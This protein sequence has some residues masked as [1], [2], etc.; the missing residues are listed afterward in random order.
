[1]KLLSYYFAIQYRAK[2]CWFWT[3]D[4]TSIDDEQH[5]VEDE[6][7]RRRRQYRD[8]EYRLVKTTCEWRRVR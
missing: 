8:H 2:G 7:E 6:I 5:R 1:M 3:T 4:K